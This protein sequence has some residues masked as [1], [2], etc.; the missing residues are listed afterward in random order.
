MVSLQL[1]WV[2]SFFNNGFISYLKG[3]V[4]ERWRDI[5]FICQLTPQVP[6]VARSG[7]VRSQELHLGLLCESRGCRLPLLSRHI[8]RE[9]NRSGETGTRVGIHVGW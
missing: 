3:I 2:R 7:L 9:L 1:M 4:R 6:A 8:S 5:P